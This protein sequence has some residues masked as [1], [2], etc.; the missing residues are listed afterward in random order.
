VIFRRGPSKWVQIIKWRTDTDTFGRGQ[1]FHGRI[2]ETRSDLSPSGERLIYIAHQHRMSRYNHE[3]G[4]AWTAV[5]KLPYLTALALWPTISPGFGGGLFDT[6][7]HVRIW[8]PF[9][10]LEPHPDFEPVES[11]TYEQD[12]LEW[13]AT[14]PMHGARLDRDGWY[15]IQTW[16]GKL[17]ADGGPGYATYS[18]EVR[19]KAGRDGKQILE[20]KWAIAD[21]EGT[22]RFSVKNTETETVQSL[23]G[24]A[25]ADWD[26]AGRLVFVADGKVFAGEIGLN[27][28]KRHELADFNGNK[29]EEVEAP[30]WAKRW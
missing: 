9:D 15:K 3:I 27:G 12:W 21:F 25:W 6:E 17:Y 14:C 18:P 29:F 1:W 22:V 2:D 23:D 10:D 5:S 30:D 24:A 7:D 16:H 26:Q 20:M 28:I 4:Y 19:E 13:D 8:Y 11:F